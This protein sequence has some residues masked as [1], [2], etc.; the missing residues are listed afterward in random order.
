MSSV[1]VTK[2]A[3]GYQAANQRPACMNCKHGEELR[4]D[5]MPPFDTS[6]WQCVRFGFFT[7][8]MATCFQH[9]AK[10]PS[11]QGNRA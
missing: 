11:T 6:S 5:R 2:F 1:Q 10:Y 3:I 4:A 7:I 8:A 9:H